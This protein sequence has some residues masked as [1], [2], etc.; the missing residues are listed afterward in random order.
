MGELKPCPF[1]GDKGEPEIIEVQQPGRLVP[2]Y[3]V[4]CLVCGA[5]TYPTLDRER[6]AKDWNRRAGDVH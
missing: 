5:M 1:C 4:E 2:S 3:L 6:A